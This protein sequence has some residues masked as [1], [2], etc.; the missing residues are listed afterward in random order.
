MSMI[1]KIIKIV[2]NNKLM[3]K[4]AKLKFVLQIYLH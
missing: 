3:N 1:V 2:A 4:P